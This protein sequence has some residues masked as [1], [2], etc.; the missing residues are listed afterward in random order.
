MYDIFFRRLKLE[1][2][3]ERRLDI[4][5]GRVVVYLRR[6]PWEPHNQAGS[7]VIRN[8]IE[9]IDPA[10]PKDRVNNIL[11]E[12]KLP[13]HLVVADGRNQQFLGHVLAFNS[14]RARAYSERGGP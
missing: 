12:N 1:F 2:L 9:G 13:H 10:R 7:S 11:D 8:R 4:S 6:W 5:L 3:W 14:Q